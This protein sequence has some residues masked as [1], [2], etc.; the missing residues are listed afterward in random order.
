MNHETEAGVVHMISQQVHLD[1]QVEQVKNETVM[2]P[3]F[4]TEDAFRIFDIDDLG[5][6]TAEDM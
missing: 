1:K 4:N 5:S 6:I 2:R 3:D